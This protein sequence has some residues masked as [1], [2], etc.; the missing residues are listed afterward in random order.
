MYKL[1][2]FSALLTNS[3]NNSIRV[4]FTP[5]FSAKFL[6]IVNK[7]VWSRKAFFFI[8]IIGITY[9]S[10]VVSCVTPI[11]FNFG[12]FYTLAFFVLLA[13]QSPINIPIGRLNILFEDFPLISSSIQQVFTP[14]GCYALENVF[15]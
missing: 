6:Y 14:F 4:L 12:Y 5:T 13:K 1:I 15:S 9:I 10:D 11:F 7:F 8:L 2:V 3:S